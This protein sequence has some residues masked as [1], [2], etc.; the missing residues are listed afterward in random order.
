MANEVMEE[1]QITLNEIAEEP[2]QEKQKVEEPKQELV[3]INNMDMVEQGSSMFGNV[4]TFKE[5]YVM[6]QNL[7]KASLVP[8][9]YQGKPMDCLIAIDIANRMG[10]SPMV[11]MQNLWVVRGVPSWSGQACMGIIK[12]CNRY[13]DVKYV[14]TGEK[15]KDTWGCYVSAKDE[16]SGEEIHGAEVTLDMAKKEGWYEKSGS[17]WKTMPELMLSYRA[18]AFFARQYCPNELMGFKV[19]GEVDDVKGVTKAVNP[20]EGK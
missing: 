20:F 12:S 10:V 11:V 19:E 7:A 2:M 15:G 1:K 5:A 6:A 9:S 4:A 14:Y 18:A 17:K 8:Q 3:E 13:K 16:S